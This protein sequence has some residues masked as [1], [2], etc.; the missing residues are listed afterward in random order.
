ME[1]FQSLDWDGVV[2]D[3]EALCQ[4]RFLPLFQSLDWD[5][6]V[7]DCQDD[8]QPTGHRNVSI[9]RLGWG[10]F[11]LLFLYFIACLLI[12]SIP[13]LGWGGFRLDTFDL[14]LII[15]DEFQ[16]LDWDGVVSDAFLVVLRLITAS[17]NPSIGMGWFQTMSSALT[18]T[19]NEVF[20]SLDWDGV[21]S[22]LVGVI[23]SQR[24]YV[25]S[26]PRLGWGGFRLQ[27]NPFLLHR[28][29]SF[30]PSIG[31]GWFQTEPAPAQPTAP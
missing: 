29:R 7:S 3:L 8:A 6:V 21:V 10:G 31:M 1:L 24:L 16:S 15:Q 17:F 13:R 14:A 23:R 22:D 19:T 25:V 30:N 12:V 2:S 4:G 11:R 20:Q 18:W 9:P 27:H 28:H 26:I 5:G